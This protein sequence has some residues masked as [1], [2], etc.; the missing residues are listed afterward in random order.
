MD[1]S[2]FVGLEYGFHAMAAEV[3]DES[4]ELFITEPFEISGEEGFRD[5]LGLRLGLGLGLGF[6]IS[7]EERFR[8]ILEANP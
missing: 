8:D 2:D 3:G 7:G 4:E 5:I 6:E 1:T